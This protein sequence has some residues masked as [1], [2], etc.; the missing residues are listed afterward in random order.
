MSC[1]HKVS[2]I[3]DEEWGFRHWL[4]YTSMTEA[5]LIEWWQGVE[6]FVPIWENI[7]D[8]LPG[9]LTLI[10]DDLILDMLRTHQYVGHIHMDDDSY[11]F[12]RLNEHKYIHK[13]FD[14]E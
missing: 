5:E 11:L 1:E 2:I 10:D 12:D 3:I 6:S 14:H 7:R 9:T 8:S 4:W 13:G